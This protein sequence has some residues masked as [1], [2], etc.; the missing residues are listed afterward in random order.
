MPDL[1]SYCGLLELNEV[2]AGKG[3]LPTSF[4]FRSNSARP[5]TEFRSDKQSRPGRWKA[6]YRSVDGDV[7]L[8]VVK[9]KARREPTNWQV[10]GDVSFTNDTLRR[11]WLEHDNPPIY[12]PPPREEFPRQRQRRR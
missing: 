12:E 4:L 11:T 6:L 10:E 1:P 7:P 2:L 5:L 3:H 9:G 8:I